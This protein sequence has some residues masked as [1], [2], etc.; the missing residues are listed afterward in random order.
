VENQLIQNEENKNLSSDASQKKTI[1]SI[2]EFS[3]VGYSGSSKK[4]NQDAF[5]IYKN[6]AGNTNHIY[7]GVWY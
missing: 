5:F 3:K 1:K 6:F 7:L 2:H 4:V